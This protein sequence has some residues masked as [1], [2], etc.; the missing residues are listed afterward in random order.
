M[1]LRIL[2][3]EDEFLIAFDLEDLMSDFGH[4]VV[5]VASDMEAALQIADR[6]RPDL[7]T[8]DLRLKQG[9][10]GADVARQLKERYGIPSL[11]ISGNLDRATCRELAPL[12]PAG[13]LGKPVAPYLLR[14]ALDAIDKAPIGGDAAS[15]E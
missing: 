15:A 10:R 1:T 6:H 13:F 12:D 2:V 11:F 9:A 3:V 8:V 14:T 7:A 5:G 4:E